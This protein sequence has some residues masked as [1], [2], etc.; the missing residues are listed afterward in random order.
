MDLAKLLTI[1]HLSHLEPVFNENELTL[2]LLL[3]SDNDYLQSILKEAFPKLGDRLKIYNIVKQCREDQHGN[4]DT[5]SAEGGP[6]ILDSSAT[7]TIILDF[8][9][10]EEEIGIPVTDSSVVDIEFSNPFENVNE[11][12]NICVTEDAF[13]MK[14]CTVK[15]FIESELIGRA[16]ISKYQ[17]DSKL[18]KCDR[19][20]L[21]HLLIDGMLE[22]HTVISSLMLEQMAQKIVEIFPNEA[23]ST[24]FVIHHN[25]KRKVTAGKLVDR[26]RNQKHYIKK[27][28]HSSSKPDV[29]CPVSDELEDKVTF[30]K[31]CKEPWK[32][33]LSSWVDT[34]DIRSKDVTASG[35]TFDFIEK[36]AAIKLPLGYLLVCF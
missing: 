34:Y 35:S 32:K 21:V 5:K 23:K 12:Q 14:S 10:K 33:I 9:A 11:A 30:M 2:E 27:C 13:F 16:I 29:D 7:D 25:R 1:H 22:R 19:Q 24:Y 28:S 4:M 17:K 15:Q 8:E 36:W 18:D 31:Y 3:S 26:Y 6:E 20:K